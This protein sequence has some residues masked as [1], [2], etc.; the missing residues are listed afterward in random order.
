MFFSPLYRPLTL[1]IFDPLLRKI[2]KSLILMEI[3]FE[4]KVELEVFPLYYIFLLQQRSLAF[5]GFVCVRKSSEIKRNG[6]GK[7]GSQNNETIMMKK[8]EGTVRVIQSSKTGNFKLFKTSF[9][10][11]FCR[12]RIPQLVDYD[13][14]GNIEVCRVYR[15]SMSVKTVELSV[16]QSILGCSTHKTIRRIDCMILSKVLITNT[17]HVPLFANFFSQIFLAKNRCLPTFGKQRFAANFFF[18]SF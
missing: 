9:I 8:I 7:N 15:S 6:A 1:L 5:L 13:F 11:Q 4:K 10:A 17:G 14:L 3:F 18:A 16:V 12:L 2:S